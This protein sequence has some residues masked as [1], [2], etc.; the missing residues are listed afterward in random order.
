MRPGFAL[1][2]PAPTDPDGT[3]HPIDYAHPPLGNQLQTPLLELW[4]S[5]SAQRLRRTALARLPTDQR[6][7][8]PY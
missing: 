4:N 2:P 3:V 7:R 1:D 8:C 6:Q 5:E